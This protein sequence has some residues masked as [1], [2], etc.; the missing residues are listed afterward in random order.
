MRELSVELGKRRYPIQIGSGL[1]K[2]PQA[3]AALAPG[4]HAFVL[5]DRNVAKY[6]WTPI[7]EALADKTVG[8]I[9]L[10]AGEQEKNFRRYTEIIHALGAMSANRDATVFA[11]GGGVVGDLA[12]FAAATWMRGIRLVQIPTTLL[13]MVDS[14]VGGKTAIDLPEGKNLVG[15]FHQP[16]AVIADTDT[17]STLPERELRS[18]FAEVIKYGAIGDRAFFDWLD[19]NAQGLLLRDPELLAE[20]IERSCAHKAA[21]VVRDETEQ[22]ERMLLNFGHTFAHALEAEQAY[23]GFRHGEA[24]A[25]GMVLAAKLSAKLGRASREDAEQLSHLL[26]RFGLPTQI[27]SGMDPNA[28]LRRMQLDKKSVSGQIRLILWTGIGAAD[29]VADVD[30]K[31]ILGALHG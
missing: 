31:L 24:V 13:A 4:R 5:S 14:S 2:N 11:L 1:L 20:A 22:G 7:E 18:G 12:G 30:T 10:P 27:P 29:V 6:Y 19:K 23:G 15:A 26:S 21:I 28:M 3:L 16:S 25:V 8:V 17:L 9:T